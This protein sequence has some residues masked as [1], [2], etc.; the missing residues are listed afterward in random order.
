MKQVTSEGPAAFFGGGAQ[1]LLSDS[2]PPP[3]AR[4]TWGVWRCLQRCNGGVVGPCPGIFWS[5]LGDKSPFQCRTEQ[6]EGG[7]LCPPLLVTWMFS[8][9]PGLWVGWLPGAGGRKA[10]K[11][12]RESRWAPPPGCRSLGSW[13]PEAFGDVPGYGGQFL[14]LRL[15]LRGRDLPLHPRTGLW[16]PWRGS[17]PTARV[18]DAVSPQC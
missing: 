12:L 11:S 5:R 4:G 2:V 15:R 18:S 9:I 10:A 8:K 14:L 16:A 3:P 17:P 1:S 6:E 13:K 7:G